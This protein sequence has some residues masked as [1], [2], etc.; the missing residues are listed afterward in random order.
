[1][2]Q[3]ATPA[4]LPRRRGRPPG[5]TPALK[6]PV[7]KPPAAKTAA[8]APVPKPPAAKSP[9]AKPSVTKPATA[10]TS[11]AKTGAA[12]TGA[13]KSTVKRGIGRPAADGA[14][15]GREKLLKTACDLLKVTPPNKLTRFLVAQ[16]ANVD[17]SL[18]RYYFRDRISLLAAAAERL[19]EQY[20]ERLASEHDGTDGKSPL[21]DRLAAQVALDVSYAHFRRLVLDELVGS[22][23]APARAAAN[24]ITQRGAAAYRAILA[25]GQ[26]DGTMRDE[27]AAMLFIAVSALSSYFS[28]AKPIYE[29]ATGQRI[30][31]PALAE[32]YRAFV[33]GLISRGMAAEGAGKAKRKA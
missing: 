10:K 1:M 13:K 18:I 29:A 16:K 2:A 24:K 19:S 27:D 28:S 32:K 20:E 9:V 8:K 30:T 23:A 21:Q 7:P 3:K 25:D 5:K 31:Q 4:A 17:P 12:K 6:A 11:A 33:T 15:V 22:D 26:A 14:S